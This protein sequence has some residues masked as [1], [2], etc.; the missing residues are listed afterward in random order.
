VAKGFVLPFS[1]IFE[2]SPDFKIDIVSS[3]QGKVT[4]AT[5]D[6]VS[7][8][9]VGSATVTFGEDV[10]GRN[11][12]I[13]ITFSLAVEILHPNSTIISIRLPGFYK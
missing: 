7:P 2:N 12:S 8:V 1:G 9:G 13:N 6:Y 5:F 3:T 4:G 10:P 11:V